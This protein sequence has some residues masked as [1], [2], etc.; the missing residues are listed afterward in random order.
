[1]RSWF[2]AADDEELERARADSRVR[3]F[4]ESVTQQHHAK[5]CDLNVLMKRFGVEGAPIPVLAD[6]PS[7]YG[8]FDMDL[9]LAEAHARVRVA[10]ERFDALP[11]NLRAMFGNDPGMLWDWI[12]DPQNADEAVELGLLARSSV[13]ASGGQPGVA[14]AAVAAGELAVPST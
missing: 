1:M 13:R 4:G 8:E 5:D 3:D 7:Y 12:Q 10:Q 2:D 9:T 6:D 11:P 14:P